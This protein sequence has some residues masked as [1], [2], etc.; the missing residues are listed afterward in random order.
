VDRKGH[1]HPGHGDRVRVIN[2]TVNLQVASGS[3]VVIT[4]D[5]CD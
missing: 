2:E 3:A 1:L 5:G 4:F